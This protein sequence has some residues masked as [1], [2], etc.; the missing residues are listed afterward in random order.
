MGPSA[1]NSGRATECLVKSA[2]ILCAL[3]LLATGLLKAATP[4]EAGPFVALVQGASPLLAL[5]ELV[6]AGC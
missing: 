4:P 2:R 5:L 6:L 1:E 3:V